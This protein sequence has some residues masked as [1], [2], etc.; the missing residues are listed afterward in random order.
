MTVTTQHFY[1]FLRSCAG[2]W[3][4][5]VYIQADGSGYLLSTGRYGRPVVMAVDHFQEL[6]GEQ[7]DPAECCGQLTED[8]F[9]ALYGQS[10]PYTANTCSG[11]CP[12]TVRIRWHS[13]ARHNAYDSFPKPCPPGE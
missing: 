11:I 3:R 2:N 10:K 6:A 7:I 1:R 5:A 9:K 13:Y 12:R 8:G 4:N